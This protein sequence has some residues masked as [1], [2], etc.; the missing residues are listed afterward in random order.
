MRRGPRIPAAPRP[1][2]APDAELHLTLRAEHA[3]ALRSVLAQL[4]AKRPAEPP[5]GLAGL[6]ERIHIMLHDA[7]NL[8]PCDVGGE[9]ACGVLLLLYCAELRGEQVTVSGL[10]SSMGLAHATSARRMSVLSRAGLIRFHRDE[11]DRRR[12]FVVLTRS[13]FGIVTSWLEQIDR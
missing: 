3:R 2:A 7:R 1:S 11:V 12:R 9:T 10:G 4:V 8:L 6:A 13:A 5:Q